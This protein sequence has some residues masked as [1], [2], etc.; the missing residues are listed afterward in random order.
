MVALIKAA[1][2]AEAA[3]NFAAAFEAWTRLALEAGRADFYCQVA[4]VAAELERWVDAEEA[5]LGALKVD[6]RFSNAMLGIGLL[7]LTRTDGDQTANAK[8][9]N[10]W[11][12]RALEIDRTAVALGLLGA[13]YYRLGEKKAAKEAFRA[14]IKADRS[15]DE[16]YFNLGILVAEDGDETEAEGL[17]RKA[18]QLDPC[19]LAAHGRLGILLQKQGR[20]REAESEFRRCTEIDP[21]DYFSHLYLADSLRIE[22]REVEAEREYRKA[23]SIRPGDAPALNL[24][25]DYL[26]SLSR[27]EEANQLRAQLSPNAPLSGQRPRNRENRWT[28][29]TFSKFDRN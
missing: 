24:F 10:L 29:R 25:A 19:F 2:Q 18:I 4:R 12:L 17:L 14:A 13:A 16:A 23:I 3:E 26:E 22:G 8:V 11:L 6:S 1:R 28:I 9:A 15:Y 27:K 20:H 7:F 5:F 21:S